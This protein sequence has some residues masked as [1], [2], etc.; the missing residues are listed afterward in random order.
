MEMIARRAAA[1]PDHSDSPMVMIDIDSIV[2]WAGNPRQNDEAAKRL[3]VLIQEHG[4]VNPVIIWSGNGVMYAGHTRVK[5]A[6]LLGMTRVPARFIAFESEE[7][8]IA[9]GLADNRANE[10]ASWDVPSLTEE[11]NKLDSIDIAKIARETGFEQEEIEGLRVGY[12]EPLEEKTV[13]PRE[14]RI[15]T[16]PHCGGEIAIA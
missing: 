16:C 1:I 2:P 10:W 5:A 4:F 14:P 3:A 9:F 8:A 12:V 15:V 6:R 11:L 7:K 13:E